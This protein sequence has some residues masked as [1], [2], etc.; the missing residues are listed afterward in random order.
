L[1]KGFQFNTAA[2]L[3]AGDA[4]IINALDLRERHIGDY[5]P[6]YQYNGPIETTIHQIPDVDLFICSETLEHLDNPD[7]VL[8]DIRNKTKWLFVSTPMGETS[9]ENPEHYWGWDDKGVREMLESA[10]F[11]TVV[12]ST[13]EFRSPEYKYKYQMW[14]AK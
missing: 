10:G 14:V 3:S 1:L 11:E 5:A 13:L 4:S 12:L 8:L 9:D 7:S 2:D 6:S